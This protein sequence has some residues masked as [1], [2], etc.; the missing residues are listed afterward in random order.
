MPAEASESE[1]PRPT[2]SN[3]SAHGALFKL[4][5]A[6]PVH[7]NASREM[8]GG[9]NL[10]GSSWTVLVLAPKIGRITWRQQT[11]DSAGEGVVAGSG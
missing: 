1:A 5:T 2:P 11:R 6:M 7:L 9:T 10:L 8:T 3:V 4:D